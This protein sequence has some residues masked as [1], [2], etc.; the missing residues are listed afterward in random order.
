MSFA[1][2]N[3]HK[4]KFIFQ[5]SFTFD[6]YFIEINPNNLPPATQGRPTYTTIPT[7]RTTT[8]TTTKSTTTRPQTTSRI[9]FIPVTTTTQNMQP[10]KL[11]TQQPNYYK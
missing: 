7:T 5:V 3:Y 11:L 9:S 8:A 4:L 6:L 1:I 10:S 2:L